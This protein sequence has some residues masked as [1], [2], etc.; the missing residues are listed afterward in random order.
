VL[1]VLYCEWPAALIVTPSKVLEE[2]GVDVF[3]VDFDEFES[4]VS[5]F[6]GAFGV[7][8]VTDCKQSTMHAMVS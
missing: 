1:Y 5:A 8:A 2:R 4:L 3:K 7:Y 6:T